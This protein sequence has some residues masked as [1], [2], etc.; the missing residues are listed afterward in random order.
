MMP[1]KILALECSCPDASAALLEGE[2]EIA[3]RSWHESRARHEGLFPIVDTLLREAGWHWEQVDLMITGRGPGAYS[4]LR[5]SL[6]ATQALAAPSGIPVLAVSGMEAAA[7]HY[8]QQSGQPSALVIGDARRQ[9]IWHGIVHADQDQR[10]P[11]VWQVSPAG[12]GVPEVD[13]PVLTPHAEAPAVPAHAIRLI[14]SATA[15]ARLAFARRQRNMP[16]E[17]LAP[18]YLHAA[19]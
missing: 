9:C 15:T 6:L 12:A 4:G 19:V 1:E 11:V 18:L 8:L 7:W 2:T 16:A 13:G 3:S 5:V 14:P 17:P 10:G